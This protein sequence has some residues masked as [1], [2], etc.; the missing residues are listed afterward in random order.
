MSLVQV[1][2]LA[3]AVVVAVAC[4]LP[5]TYLVLRRMAML[6]D[7][8]SHA[9]LPGLVVGFLLAGRVTSPLLM[10]GAA[11][12]GVATAA[13]VEAVT[14]SGRAREDAAI[15]LVFPALF[16]LGVVMIAR[17]ADRVHLDTDAV[18]LGELAFVPFDRLA[19]FGY[20]LGPRAL[21]IGGGLLTLNAAFVGLLRKELAL[22]TFDEAHA[23]T[24]GFAPTLVQ[25]ALVVVVSIT[26]VGAFDAVGSVLVVAFF[27]GPPATALFFARRLRSVLLLAAGIAV[28]CAL[29]GYGL[30][31]VL[32]ASIAGAMA[33]AVGA[34]FGVAALFA[35]ERGVV[36]RRRLLARQRDAF[37]A[38]TL[39]VHLATHEGSPEAATECS[40]RHLT[41]HLHWA[42]AF[43]ARAVE[44]AARESWVRAEGDRLYLTPQGRAAVASWGAEA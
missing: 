37:A 18:L 8:I 13:L 43:A 31:R 32:D 44:R 40:R 35:P 17:F 28:V 22:T 9:V 29:A 41:D 3:V 36:A 34:A 25:L 4:A 6:S 14:R 23:S 30:A 2:I 20:D 39:A 33:L 1:E 42:P 11:L 27:A 24:L 21:W 16:A 12:A 38:R 15:G 7:A 5:G 26:S 10:V 19:A